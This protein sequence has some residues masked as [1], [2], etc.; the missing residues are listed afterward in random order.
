MKKIISL[1][2]ALTAFG[3]I[4]D[5]GQWQPHQIKK[6]QSEFDRIGMEL[7]AEQVSSLDQ[8]PLNAVVGLG[9]CSASFVSPNGLVVTNHHCAYGAIANNSTPENNLIKKGFLAKSMA[10]ELSGGPRQ[11]V[12]ITEEVTDVTDKVVG[13]LGE[14]TGKARFDAIA[15]KRKALVKACETSDDYR[16]SVRSFHHGMEYFLL[17]QLMIKDVRLVYAPPDSLGNFGGDIDNFEYPRHTADFTF[18]RAYVDKDGKSANYSKDN[19][20]FKPKSYLTVNRD[21]VKKGD[22]IIL[23]GYPG[24]TSRY[25][26]ASEI[27]F[28]GSWSYPAQVDMYNKTLATIA[29]ATKGNP[30]LEVKYSSTVKSIN[31]RMKKRMGLMDGFKVTDIHGIKLK[32]E[33]D[34]LNWIAQDKSRQQ[35]SL[36]HGELSKLIEQNQANAKRAFYARY[37]ASSSLL[38]SANTLYRLAKESQKPDSER[39][40]GYQ[41]RDINRIKSGLKRL[42]TRFDANVDL[43]LWTM[44]ISE[45]LKQ[46]DAVTIEA[47]N[48]ALGLTADMTDAQI[49]DKLAAIYAKSSL[50]DYDTRLAWVGKSVADFENS[51][52]AFIKLAVALYDSNMKREAQDKEMAGQ[53]A[54]VRPEYMKAIIAFNRSLGK[55]VYPDANGT[56]RVTFGTVDGY[57]AVDGVYKTP[58]TSLEGLAAKATGVFPFDAPETIVKAINDRDYGSYAQ[59]YVEKQFPSK[60]HCKLFGCHEKILNEFNSVPVNF[61]SSADTTGGN[62]GSPVM[63]ARGELV[64]LNFDSTYESITKDW[65]FNP[66]ITRAIHVDVR[67]MLWLMEQYGADNLIEEMKIV[68]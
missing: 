58:F 33:Q 66:R 47:F 48:K 37:A 63:N 35:Y 43:A 23:A 55:P 64:G 53:L 62:S 26:L 61:L 56:L 13:D 29:D 5:E 3:A 11:R 24:S 2:A 4:A 46:G 59:K 17:K 20:P 45:Y 36:T 54:Q 60:W 34:L 52:D 38:R 28:A 30:A 12:Y 18:L 50:A 27:D 39:E 7:S 19:V 25:K 67:Y 8:Y 32:Q 15:S 40:A 16:C 51:D 41:A 9:G 68:K 21:G 44:Y 14:L 31:N 10:E 6:L 57:P 22:G 42:K 49:H 65:Y 1:A